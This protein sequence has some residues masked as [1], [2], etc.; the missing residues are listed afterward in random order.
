[1][2]KK[3][4]NLFGNFMVAVGV[5]FVWRGLWYL[6]DFIDLNLFNNNHLF[7][8]IGGIIV[9]VIILYVPDKDLKEL[10]KL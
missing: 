3:N 1:M 9:G 4:K 10:G 5:L 6:L 2:S 7:T 8:A